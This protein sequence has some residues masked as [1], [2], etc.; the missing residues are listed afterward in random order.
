MKLLFILIIV[1]Q[2]P[3]EINPVKIV[4]GSS[5]TLYQKLI[6]PSQ[7][8]VCNFSPSCSHFG[9]GAIEKYGPIWGILMATDRLMRCNPWSYQHFNTYYEGIRDHKIYDPI[10][11]NF[12]FKE[13]KKTNKANDYR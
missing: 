12:I 10:E 8:D 7:G 3:H 2:S 9:K 1:T 4:I 11:N 13:I 5:L 6:S